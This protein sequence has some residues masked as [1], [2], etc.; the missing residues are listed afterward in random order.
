MDAEEL[1]LVRPPEL[2]QARG[3]GVERFRQVPDLVPGIG[4]H[5]E[6][7]VAAPDL[8]RRPDEAVDRPEDPS[9]GKEDENDGQRRPDG[10]KNIHLPSGGFGAPAGAVIGVAHVLLVQLQD[11]VGL[12]L[13]LAEQR[14]EVREISLIPEIR[15]LGRIDDAFQTGFVLSEKVPQ[16]GGLFSLGREGDVAELDLKGLFEG[17]L[18]VTDEFVPL[19]RMAEKNEKNS[20]VDALQGFL[21]LLAGDDAPVIFAQDDVDRSAQ[22]GKMEDALGPDDDDDDREAR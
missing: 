14:K 21:H 16:P 19:R 6:V 7:Q 12:V 13:D 5:D 10:Q 9:P 22:P 15:G 20:A 3:H 4:G 11:L 1:G 18:I 2:P 8:V 17:G